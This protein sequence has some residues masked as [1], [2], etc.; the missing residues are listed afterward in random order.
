M[1]V[2]SQSHRFVLSVNML[3]YLFFGVPW[4][5]AHGRVV[6]GVPCHIIW[7][8]G[9]YSTAFTIQACFL[10]DN[11][12]FRY[13]YGIIMPYPLFFVQGELLLRTQHTFARNVLTFGYELLG[14]VRKLRE[15]QHIIWFAGP[16]ILFVFYFEESTP[17]I[18]TIP[19]NTSLD[20]LLF[21]N[22]VS[23]AVL[24]CTF[25]FRFLNRSIVLRDN[26][27]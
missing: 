24:N 15:M 10:T 2:F 22:N 9:T 23:S 25:A 4:P 21:R 7:T 17:L 20:T 6:M 12:K 11:Y 5:M 3:S 18:H 13:V 8:P 1:A 26:C 16:F 14:P 27:R 19:P